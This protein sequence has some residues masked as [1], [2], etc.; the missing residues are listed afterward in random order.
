M[1][2]FYRAERRYTRLDLR[3]H[4]TAEHCGVRESA[5]FPV[6]DVDGL[7][8]SVFAN[9]SR[10]EIAREESMCSRE[11]GDADSAG[12]GSVQNPG[13]RQKNSAVGGIRA[14]CLGE[15]LCG[16]G[17]GAPTPHQSCVVGNCNAKVATIRSGAAA[18][19]LPLPLRWLQIR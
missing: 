18:R 1:P 13:V 11:D 7:R 14:L 8:R 19:L 12:A 17:G 3:K 2:P 9:R 15:R 6:A 4:V 10:F 16:G 5:A